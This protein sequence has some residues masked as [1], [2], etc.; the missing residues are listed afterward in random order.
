M[1]LQDLWEEEGKRKSRKTHEIIGS[2][3][4]CVDYFVSL[5]APSNS[6]LCSLLL[7]QFFPSE[8]WKPI[9]PP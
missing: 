3:V 1:K 4:F 2:P 7:T 8:K 5:R 6:T 9:S